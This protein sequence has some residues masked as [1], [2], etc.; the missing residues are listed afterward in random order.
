MNTESTLTIHPNTH[1]F[2]VDLML[3]TLVGYLRVCGYDTAYVGD[4]S[5]ETDTEITDTAHTEHRILV[6][7]DTT[8]ANQTD[9]AIRIDSQDI[10]GQ[11]SELHTQGVTLEPTTSPE[12]CGNCNTYLTPVISPTDRPTYVPSNS[13]NGLWQ[14]PACDQF[15]WQG[16][17]WDRMRST[18]HQAKNHTESATDGQ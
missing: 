18:L 10:T 13:P 4:R 15:F 3:G 11:L 5:I 7:R 1:R 17:H 8:L 2:L 6:T 12:R 14:C 16:S 9:H